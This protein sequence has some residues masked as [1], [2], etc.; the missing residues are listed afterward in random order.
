MTRYTTVRTSLAIALASLGGAIYLHVPPAAAQSCSNGVCPPVVVTAPRLGGGNVLCYGDACAGI[1]SQLQFQGPHEVE[2]G[3]LPEEPG[4]NGEA[5]CE[6]LSKDENRPDDCAADGSDVPRVPG[7]N[8]SMPAF[9]TL[10]ANGCGDGS[11]QFEAA[12]IVAI[13]TVSGY[14]GNPDEPLPG[15]QI[16]DVC[17]AHDACYAGGGAKYFCDAQFGRDLEVALQ[18]Q[19]VVDSNAYLYARNV[20]A[21]YVSA[22]GLFGDRAYN[23]AKEAFECAVWNANMEANQCER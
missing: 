20:M 22:V 11:W 21:A 4:V 12:N 13:V 8:T 18:S 3:A 7:L 19:Y 14:T 2:Q 23:N 17:N 5:F 6:E 1:L 10:H 16:R 15:L 9:L